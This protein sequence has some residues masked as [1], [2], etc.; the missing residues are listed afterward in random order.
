M[1]TEKNLEKLVEKQRTYFAEGK[2]LPVQERIRALERLGQALKS[3][4]AELCRALR[5]DLGKS[6]T[7]SYMCEI[8]LTLSELGYVKKHLRSWS[9]DRRV[10]TPLS[11]FHARSFTVQEPY[12]VVLV[13][14]PW[15]YPVLLTLEPLIG[16]L[17]AGNCCVVK[18][19]AYSPET[20]SVMAKI[21]R[22]V[23]PEEYVAVVEGGRQENQGL[24]A[25]K[26][27]YIFFTGGVNV[28]KLVMEKAS[29]HLTPVTLELGGKS[30][31]IIDETAN[32]KLAARRL[33]FGKYLNCGQTCVAPDYVLV[34]EKVKERFLGYVKEEI[35]RMYGERPLENP[36]YGKIVNRKHFDR[37]LGLMNPEKL[38]F[39]GES[40]EESLQI[41]PAVLDG[42][43]PED[44][45]M[46]EEIFGPLL[47]ILTVRS[48]EEALSFVN[49]RP[50]PLAFYIFTQ[51]K[52]VE[53]MFLR[54]AS[55]GGGCV[56][57]TIIHLATS[58]MGFGGV[59]NSGMGSYHGKKSFDT[60][61]H[62]KSIVKKY[63]WIDLPMRYQP[64]TEQK[65]KM[66][67]TF[68]K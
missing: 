46:Q 31:C 26:F 52:K 34:H 20:S 30:P 51:D 27:D 25:Q 68:L 41:A 42:V 16:A 32:L 4:E 40:R 6:R 44:A 36:D 67:R 62:E 24:L 37:L 8:G 19:S 33:A 1:E 60:F 10:R 28:G 3:S 61:S 53:Q 55:F 18:P 9:K 14:S 7:E 38:V 23:F 59:G 54:R 45:V 47:P 50:K 57:D 21:L 5:A 17:A 64:Y 65:E 22:S 56:N 39:G 35:V 29:A 48:M 43:T 66:I 58:A 11:Q 15:N 12:G 63:N 49:D 2:T 13:M